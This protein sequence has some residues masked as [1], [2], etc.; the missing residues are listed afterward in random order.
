MTMSEWIDELRLGSREEQ[1]SDF[2]NMLFAVLESTTEI[3]VALPVLRGIAEYSYEF[4]SN[5]IGAYAD[6]IIH[7]VETNNY[8]ITDLDNLRQIMHDE[9]E[10]PDTLQHT[11]TFRARL[12]LAHKYGYMDYMLFSRRD[13]YVKKKGTPC[14][15]RT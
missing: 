2:Y 12:E 9:F 1:A 14:L 5:A 8:T 7:D 6:A 10:F 11:K 15:S 4:I 13:D 3:P